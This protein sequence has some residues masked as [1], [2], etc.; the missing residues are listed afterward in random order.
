MEVFEFIFAG[1]CF[2]CIYGL[3]YVKGRIDQKKQ[4]IEFVSNYNEGVKK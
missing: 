3:G 1:V 2:A 4:A